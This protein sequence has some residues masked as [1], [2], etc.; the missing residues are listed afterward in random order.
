[1]SRIIKIGMDVHTTNYTLCAMEPVFCNFEVKNNIILNGTVEPDV[2][3]IEAFINQVKKLVNEDCN[4]LCGYE[5]GCLGY[6]LFHEL[7][8]RNINCVILAPSTMLEPKSGRRIKTDTRDAQLIAECLLKPG[9]CSY[10]YIPSDKDDDV[11]TYLRMRDDHKIHL[12]KI[13]QQINAFCL[14]QGY[15]YK[16]QFWSQT[17]IQWLRNLE[18]DSMDRETLDEYFITYEYLRD[19]VER[20]DKRIEEIAMEKEYAESVKKLICFLGVRTHT[21][22][23]LLVEVGDFTRF[24]DAGSFAAYLGLVPGEASSAE[25]VNRLS[26]TKAGNSHLRR[27]LVESAHGICR[28]QVGYKSKDLKAR[29]YGNSAEVIAY[30]DKANVRLRRKYYRMILKGKNRNVAVTSI[31]REL[32]CFIWG[33]MNNKIAFERCN[34][35]QAA[36]SQG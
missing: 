25:H 35:K 6:S 4:I 3:N 22:L 29:Q 32:A 21:A 18:L 7:A 23:S 27:L 9:G 28:G 11:K 34:I 19:K 17:H 2:K 33:M 15:H 26:I 16:K 14:L 20:L 30:A 31:A 24:K 8:K 10:V 1:M 12:K 5:A 36:V 13:K